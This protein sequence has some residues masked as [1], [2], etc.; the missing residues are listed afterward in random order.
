MFPLPKKFVEKLLSLG[1]IP[2][3][4]AEECRFDAAPDTVALLGA[5]NTAA[6]NAIAI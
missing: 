2:D 4:M 3:W 1:D 6:M 5:G